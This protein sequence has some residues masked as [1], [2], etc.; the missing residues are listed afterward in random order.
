MLFFFGCILL[1]IFL[2]HFV[3]FF[4]KE[5]RKVSVLFSMV[6][7]N[8]LLFMFQLHNSLVFLVCSFYNSLGFLVCS[9]FFFF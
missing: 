3:M 4:Y 7:K 6:L 9:F 8:F 5:K 1:I 2:R